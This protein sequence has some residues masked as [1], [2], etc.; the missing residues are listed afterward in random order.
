MMGQKVREVAQVEGLGSTGADQPERRI[1]ESCHGEIADDPAGGIEHGRQDRTSVFS[2]K[3]AGQK[4]IEEGG[5][6]RTLDLVAGEAGDLDHADSPAQ[7][8]AF[9]PHGGEPVGPPKGGNVARFLSGIGKPQGALETEGGTEDRSVVCQQVMHRRCLHR[10]SRLAFLFRPADGESFRIG[11]GRA[12]QDEGPVR[13]VAETGDIE[14]HHVQRRHAFENPLGQCPAHAGALG[15]SG[16][17]AGGDKMALFAR[18]R[19]DESRAV[20]RPHHRA[21]DDPLHAG[22]SEAGN[23]VDGGLHVGGDAVDVVGQEFHAKVVRRT[24]NGPVDTVALIAPDQHAAAFLAQVEFAVLV[25]GQRD[26]AVQ[27]GDL[28][29]VVGDD[30]LVLHG[31]ERQRVAGHGGHLPCPQSRG[32][33]DRFGNDRAGLRGDLPVAVAAAREAGHRR[34]SRDDTAGLA[35]AFGKG[36][37]H[38]GRID[39][40][41]RR[42][43][44]AAQNPAG[45]DKRIEPADVVEADDL[46]VLAEIARPRPLGLQ[47]V[48]TVR[49]GGQ[50]EPATAMQTA[51]LPGFLLKAVIEPQRIVLQAGKTG[52][53][54][55]GMDVG[56]GMPCRSRRQVRALKQ[57]DV[58][59]AGSHQMPGDRAANDTAA[60]NDDTGMGLHQDTSSALRIPVTR[61]ILQ[62]KGRGRRRCASSFRDPVCRH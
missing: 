29:D 9:A 60:H 34:V 3:P 44:H 27:S 50:I 5:G 37:G 46:E 14:R 52:V 51:R 43:P 19:T 6:V 59:A 7:S 35:H 20:G 48:E 10:P 62:G 49:A 18:D 42:P 56:G 32:V 47:F 31:N 26:F 39:M 11:L 54:V 33:D 38:S 15:E 55:H 22:G 57:Q 41:I 1:A 24:V 8:P 12:C 40:A 28:G 30:I 4:M 17:H 21:I 36:M 45:I 13:P 25:A 23:D 2:G 53:G 16:Y 61:A 58:T